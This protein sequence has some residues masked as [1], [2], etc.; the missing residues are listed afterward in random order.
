MTKIFVYG[1]LRK[2]MYNYDLYLKKYH[3]YVQ[4]AYVKGTLYSLKDAIYPALIEG[5]KMILGE[6]HEVPYHV[7]S[8]V[9]I[10]EGY[11]GTNNSS[12]EYNRDICPIYNRH[13]KIIAHL[14][15]YTFNLSN[16][17]NVQRLDK[18][19]TC[20]DYVNYITNQIHQ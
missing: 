4:E 12:N 9:D 13:G 6:I 7:L 11:N 17:T 16:P 1:S 20:L 15:V 14:P 8:A 2:G 10:M 18:E 19:I 5:D 3:T